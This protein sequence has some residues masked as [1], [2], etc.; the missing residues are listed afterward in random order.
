MNAAQKKALT[1]IVS[2]LD[3][4]KTA[5]EELYGELQGAYDD[6]SEKWQEGEKGQAASGCIET[7]T[8]A[9]YTLYNT[10]QDLDGLTS[11]D[12]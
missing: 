5:L 10:I 9:A 2:D 7:L 3:A 4:S 6:K 8:E 12:D 1:S 11:T